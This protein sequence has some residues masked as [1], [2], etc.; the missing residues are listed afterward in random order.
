MRKQLSIVLVIVLFIVS[1]Q[2][3]V[4]GKPSQT[5]MAQPGPITFENSNA[6]MGCSAN[7]V[8]TN[9][10]EETR[11]RGNRLLFGNSDFYS[12]E[13]SSQ[14]HYSFNPTQG[15]I[16]GDLAVSYHRTLKEGGY[17]SLELFVNIR[18]GKMT[19]DQAQNVWIF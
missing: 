16:T 3:E 4:S 18:S 5:I 17:S 11:E 12:D 13:Q 6:Y 2:S 8:T 10:L 19:W 9:G 1:G 7:G 14:F 15:S